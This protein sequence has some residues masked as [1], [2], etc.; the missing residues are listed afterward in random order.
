MWSF[1]DE[2]VI[3]ITTP[4]LSCERE[5]SCNEK[6]ART[7]GKVGGGRSGVDRGLFTSFCAWFGSIDNVEG[8][9]VGALGGPEVFLEKVS[10]LWSD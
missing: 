6:L 4:D 3:R 10:K 9:R 1:W 2:I 7:R 5:R 8:E